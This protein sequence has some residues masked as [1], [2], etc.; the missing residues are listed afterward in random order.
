[1]Q[2]FYLLTYGAFGLVIG[3][4]LNVVIYRLPRNESIVY[5]GSRC[6]A[7]GCSLK[8]VEL[9]PLF[10]FL[11]QRGRCR[12]CKVRISWR[13]PF[14]EMMT[15]MLFMLTVW[16]GFDLS[17]GRLILNLIFVAVLI[18]LSF[19]DADHMCLPD[20]LVLPLLAI[21]LAGAFFLPGRPGGPEAFGSAAG[22]GMLFALIA[23][24]VPE[25]MGWG[26]VKLVAAMG[27]FLGFPQIMMAI[28]LGSLIGAIVGITLIRLKK[29]KAKQHLPFGPFLAIG[30]VCSLFW[31]NVFLDQYGSIFFQ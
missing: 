4:F 6:P 1:M 22:A 11:I 25:G 17:P 28:F 31:G 16:I 20:I 14:V 7:C 18:A 15:G 24:F 12:N 26:D 10:S 5:P 23:F 19:I 27:A 30:A 3:S 29:M 8:A 9:I 21:G 2:L 13:Y